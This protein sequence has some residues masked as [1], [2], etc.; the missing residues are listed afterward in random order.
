MKPDFRCTSHDYFE[1]ELHIIHYT[2]EVI[3]KYFPRKSSIQC[4]VIIFKQ[5]FRQLFV[6]YQHLHTFH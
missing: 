3:I 6:Q 5:F 4:K 1:L 2:L